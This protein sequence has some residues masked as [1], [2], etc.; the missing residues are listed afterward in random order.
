MVLNQIK[1]VWLEQRIPVD[2][3]DP[4]QKTIIKIVIVNSS[5]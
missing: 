4:G 1:E 2:R 5:L 3:N